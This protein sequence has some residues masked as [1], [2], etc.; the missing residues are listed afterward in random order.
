MEPLPRPAP[1]VE[2]ATLARQKQEQ[3][4]GRK[5]L[6]WCP[7]IIHDSCN[8]LVRRDANSAR[9]IRWIMM[10]GPSNQPAQLIWDAHCGKLQ[11]R[12]GKVLDIN[13]LQRTHVGGTGPARSAAAAVIV[14]SAPQ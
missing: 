5:E 6:K 13:M 14:I 7:D 1:E 4:Q 10:R 12:V 11:K 9:S 8:S 3:G 2:P